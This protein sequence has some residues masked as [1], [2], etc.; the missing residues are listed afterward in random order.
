MD[1]RWCQPGELMGTPPSGNRVE[2]TGIT[3]ER[4][5]GGKIV[6][7]WNNFDQLGMV[8]QIGAIPEPEW[9]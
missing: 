8:R 2:L 6:E 7:T 5:M 3:I 9:T 1:G 4:I